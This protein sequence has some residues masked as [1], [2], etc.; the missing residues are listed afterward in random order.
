MNIRRDDQTNLE[1]DVA[2]LKQLES[3]ECT[4]EEEAHQGFGDAIRG[5][6]LQGKIEDLENLVIEDK[7]RLAND[8]D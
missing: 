4:V 1:R 7:E 8:R 3:E 5:M 2:K 6:R